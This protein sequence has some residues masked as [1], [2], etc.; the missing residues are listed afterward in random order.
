[1]AETQLPSGLLRKHLNIE[2]QRVTKDKGKKKA[3]NYQKVGRL[4]SR[5]QFPLYCLRFISGYVRVVD[6]LCG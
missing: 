2:N 1:M 4:Q 6:V 5:A 3:R